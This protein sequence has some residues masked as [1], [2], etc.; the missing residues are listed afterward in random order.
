LPLLRKI[1]VRFPRLVQTTAAIKAGFVCLPKLIGNHPPGGALYVSYRLLAHL[2]RNLITRTN[3]IIP[4]PV[5]VAIFG[6]IPAAFA[7]RAADTAV[8]LRSPAIT[9]LNTVRVLKSVTPSLIAS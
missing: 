5:S 4:A 3:T 7:H 9:I 2:R 1:L 6:L 8:P